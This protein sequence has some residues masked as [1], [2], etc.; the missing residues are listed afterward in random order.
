MMV[1]VRDRKRVGMDEKTV[2]WSDTRLCEGYR[3]L[4]HMG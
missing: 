4:L 1:G 2:R 3:F